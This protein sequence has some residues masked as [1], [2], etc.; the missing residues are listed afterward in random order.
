[1]LLTTSTIA[2][3]SAK[4]GDEGD[5]E[6]I[7]VDVQITIEN[8]NWQDV[9]VFAIRGG[10]RV[11]L[12]LVTSQRTETFVVKSEM[13][14][15]GQ[16]HLLA[17]PVGSLTTYDSGEVRIEPGDQV[18]WTLAANLTHSAIFVF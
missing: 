1:M 8:R 5:A 7:E 12:G 4:S 16:F 9:V 15:T 18:R 6:P 17:D 3:C 13:T 10:N 2:A 14:R 11:R